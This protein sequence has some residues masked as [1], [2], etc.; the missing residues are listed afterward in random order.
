M[1]ASTAFRTSTVFGQSSENHLQY[2]NKLE[3]ESQRRRRKNEEEDPTTKPGVVV[4]AE[5]FQQ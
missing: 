1:H 3:R 4:S 2:N 5:K